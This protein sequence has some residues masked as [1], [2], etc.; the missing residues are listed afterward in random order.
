MPFKI[1]RTESQSDLDKLR[2]DIEGLD[3]T[4]FIERDYVEDIAYHTWNI[5]RYR[6]VATGIF[7]NALRQ[8][9]AQILNEI[10]LPPSKVM[11]IES[12]MSSQRLSYEWLFDLESKRQLVSLLREAGYDE[13]A[14]EAK[15]YVLVAEDL[16]NA[17]R[18]LKSAREGRDKAL[19]SVAKYRKSLAVQLRRNSDRVLADQVPLIAGGEEN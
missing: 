11:A 2:A 19:R 3:P 14:I 4:D 13:S 1:L 6:R 15:A 8:A 5:R 12:W 18:M 16:E 7:D 9:L 17:N 10:L